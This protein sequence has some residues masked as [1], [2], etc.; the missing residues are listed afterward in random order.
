MA[1][2]KNNRLISSIYYSNRAI[3]SVYKG[4]KLIWT[5]DKNNQQILSCFSNG[6][7]IDEYPWDDNLSW[8]D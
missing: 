2:Y 8:T 3:K 6:Y 1:I 4:Y 5:K 7:W